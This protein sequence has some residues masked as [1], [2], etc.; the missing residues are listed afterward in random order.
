M[1]ACGAGHDRWDG[2]CPVQQAAAP[3]SWHDHQA[4]ETNY[5]GE[6]SWSTRNS[7]QVGQNQAGIWIQVADTN[8]D[9]HISLEEAQA[10]AFEQE[11][12]GAGTNWP[13]YYLK[14]PLSHIIINK[15]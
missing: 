6:L 12:I 8:A 13:T 9:G 4:G 2:R 7:S 10:I 11:G 1:E 15:N 14:F 3:Y 5:E